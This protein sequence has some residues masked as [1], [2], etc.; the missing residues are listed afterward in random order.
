MNSIIAWVG[1]KKQLREEIIKL[2]PTDKVTM[3]V[4]VFGGAGWVLFGRDKH[5]KNEVYNDAN[6]NLVN[7]FRCIKYHREELAREL[8]YNIFSREN[9]N[10]RRALLSLECLTD[11]KRA[12]LFFTLIKHSFGSKGTSFATRSRNMKSAIKRFDE[13][14]ERLNTVVIEHKDFEDLIKLYDKKETL[15]YLDP[16]YFGTEKYYNKLEILFT[17]ED[18][19]RLKKTLTKVKGRWILSYNDSDY[20]R[21]LYKDYIIIETTRKETLSSGHNNK[22]FKELIIK[23]FE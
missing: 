6:S 17:T 11:I 13:V 18:H 15:F 14:A 2:F 16:P 9:F 10:I 4:E 3:Y 21:E 19:L 23:N 12:S 8:E 20:I 5:A 22:D 1:G 7:L